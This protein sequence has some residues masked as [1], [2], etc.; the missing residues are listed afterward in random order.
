[1]H[2]DADELVRVIM[3]YGYV[4]WLSGSGRYFA[5]QFARLVP[6]LFK[7]RIPRITKVNN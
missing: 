3:C 7:H 4:L 6:Y 5:S 1:V 2:P